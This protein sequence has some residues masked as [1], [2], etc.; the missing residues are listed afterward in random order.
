MSDIV[1]SEIRNTNQEF[2]TKF[3]GTAGDGP[4]SFA[5]TD[6]TASTQ[7]LE[8]GGTPRVNIVKYIVTGTLGSAVTITRDGDLVFSCSPE[9]APVINLTQDGI[10]DSTNNDQE[11][12]IAITGSEGS[13]AT[14]YLVMRKIEGWQTKVETVT[15][16]AYDDPTAVGVLDI[17]GAPVL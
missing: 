7:T 17:S 16:G 4:T 2:I 10:S 12:S 8:D 1:Y 5:L 15:Y 13:T 9:N 3:T 14:G 11:I 6:L